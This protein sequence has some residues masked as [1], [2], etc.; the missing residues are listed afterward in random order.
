MA[1][2][3]AF[4]LV[5]PEKLLVSQ[6]VDFVVVPGEAG[7]FA[8]LPGHA[9]LLS[10][11]RAGIIEIHEEG[12]EK[13]GL[14]VTGGFAEATPTRCTVLAQNITPMAD[15]DRTQV[16]QRLADAKDDL[17]QHAED[18]DAQKELAVAEA[19]LTAMNAWEKA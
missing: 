19:M 2:K 6:D 11:V 14:F 15:M 13:K 5:S 1:D 18:T 3:V 8:V 9:P 16:E 10:S 12:S 7:D 4:E 17:G